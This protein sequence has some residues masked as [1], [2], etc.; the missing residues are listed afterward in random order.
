MLPAQLPH[1]N[2]HCDNNYPVANQVYN[3]KQDYSNDYDGLDTDID[4]E[5]I[6]FEDKRNQVN[7]EKEWKTEIKDEEED[8]DTETENFWEPE[9]KMEE[10]DETDLTSIKENF[11]VKKEMITTL[12]KAMQNKTDKKCPYCG[13]EFRDRSKLGYH[14]L[15]HTGEKPLQV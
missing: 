14:I 2:Q 7:N 8:S 15:T 3:S 13:K 6:D 10:E 12:S 4:E 1:I 5:K 9:V 11:G